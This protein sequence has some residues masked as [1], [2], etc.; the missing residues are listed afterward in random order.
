[1]S[2]SVLTNLRARKMEISLNNSSTRD[3]L[4]AKCQQNTLIES[5]YLRDCRIIELQGKI[6]E[7]GNFRSN[8]TLK[9]AWED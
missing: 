4:R 8:E 7:F 3:Q 9:T 5:T 6:G 2:S 1:M